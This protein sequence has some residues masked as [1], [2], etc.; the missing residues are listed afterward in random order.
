M[1]HNTKPWGI[2]ATAASA[3]SIAASAIAMASGIL[4]ILNSKKY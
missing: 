4:V 2:I 1:K 3:V